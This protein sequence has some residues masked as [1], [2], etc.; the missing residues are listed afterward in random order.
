MLYV[1]ILINQIGWNMTEQKINESFDKAL[2]FIK[3]RKVPISE[4]A[5]LLGLGRSQTHEKIHQ[6]RGRKCYTHE[7]DL[8]LNYL[9]E[10]K[11]EL[12]KIV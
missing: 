11:E 4:L 2:I 5:K 9:K 3:K 7:K 8:I 6:T 12:K 10:I 1:C